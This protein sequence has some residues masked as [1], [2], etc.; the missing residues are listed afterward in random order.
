MSMI[1]PGADIEITGYQWVPPFARGF[2]RDL[3][4]RWACEE[5]GIPYRERLADV[6]GH[7]CSVRL[8]A[9]PSRYCVRKIAV[10]PA[11]FFNNFFQQLFPTTAKR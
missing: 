6:T 7:Q 1:D 9:T 10:F 3:R 5:A 4:P 2:V 8:T 11:T